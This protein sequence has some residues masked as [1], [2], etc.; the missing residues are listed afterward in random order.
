V[1]DGPLVFAQLMDF[2]PRRD[3]NACVDKYRGWHGQLAAKGV[4][5]ECGSF[6]RLSVCVAQEVV[7]R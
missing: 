1:F 4:A 3:F 6:G 7:T 2:L 5:D